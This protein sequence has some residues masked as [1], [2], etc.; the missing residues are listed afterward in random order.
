MFSTDDQMKD[1]AKIKANDD[2]KR[3]IIEAENIS[4]ENK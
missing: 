3:L 4:N 2:K 1:W